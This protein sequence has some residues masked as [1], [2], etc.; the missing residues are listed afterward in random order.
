MKTQEDREEEQKTTIEAEPPVEA[1]PTVDLTETDDDDDDGPQAA[2]GPGVPGSGRRSQ[3]SRDYIKELRGNLSALEQRFQESDRRYNDAAREL[4]ELRG[5]MAERP[6]AATGDPVQ[7]RLKAIEDQQDT[8][9][10][11]LRN[12]QDDNRAR[13]LQGQWRKL[14]NERIALIARGAA[15]QPAER[16]DQEVEAKILASEFPEIYASRSNALRAQAEMAAL[17]E[18]NAP[19]NIATARKACANVMKQLGL[20]PRPEPSAGDRARLAGTPGRPG[21]NGH[22]GQSFTPSR[23]QL[24]MARAYC[25]NDARRDL[26]DGEKVRIWVREVAKPQGL[27]S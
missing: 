14:D 11:A 26:E 18:R 27:L 7:D 22:G 6:A 13:A 24:S 23:N 16:N 25:N 5:R 4:A 2:K 19:I 1:A 15:P 8:V 10:A 20:G 12:E 21:T 3:R 9:M 17:V